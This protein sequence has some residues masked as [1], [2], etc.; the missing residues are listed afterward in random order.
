MTEPLLDQAALREA[1]RRLAGRLH[2][3]GIVGDVYLFGGRAMALAFSTRPATS[4]S[5]KSS[6]T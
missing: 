3:R 4:D 6:P 5:A 1:L 2:A